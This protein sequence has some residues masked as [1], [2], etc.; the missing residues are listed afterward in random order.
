MENKIEKISYDPRMELLK[1]YGATVEL[2]NLSENAYIV[3]FPFEDAMTTIRIVL[4]DYSGADLVIT[5]MTTLPD[6]QKNSGFGSKSIESVLS[7]AQENNLKDIRA[8]QVQTPSENFWI[9]NGFKK[10]DEPNP[11]NDFVYVG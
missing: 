8:V 3:K 6:S 10:S 2:D 11:T 9:K 7:W 1:N 4:K 5:N